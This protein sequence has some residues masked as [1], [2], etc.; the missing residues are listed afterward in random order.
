MER[1]CSRAG[2]RVDHP[3]FCSVLFLFALLIIT[4][5]FCKLR[6]RLQLTLLLLLRFKRFHV[7]VHVVV[8]IFFV[9]Y[10]PFSLTFLPAPL[11]PCPLQ[12]TQLL[13]L[14]C[15]KYYFNLHVQCDSVCVLCVCMYL[16]CVC[17]GLHFSC[18]CVFCKLQLFCFIFVV[19]YAAV[20]AILL[21]NGSEVRLLTTLSLTLT[22]SLSLSLPHTLLLFLSLSFSLSL[23]FIDLAAAELLHT[24]PAHLNI[25]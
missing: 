21:C 3:R 12:S 22:R 7:A 20:N 4:A 13:S 24:S 5:Y 11:T 14:L 8:A 15:K 2:V 10:V 1:G 19:V 25:Y 17:V 9:F 6:C 18:S 16:L 23:L